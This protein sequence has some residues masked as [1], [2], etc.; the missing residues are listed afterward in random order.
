MKIH[1]KVHHDPVYPLRNVLLLLHNEHVVVEE[2]L[3]LLV[4]K[5]D[6]DLLET[7]VLE[8]LK[9]SN[10][11]DGHKVGLLHG[12]IAERAVALGNEPLEHTVIDCPGDTT[13]TVGGLV[14]VLTLGDPLGA[15]LEVRRCLRC[16]RF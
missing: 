4:D 1:S 5:V 11:Q 14:D 16:Y 12:G 2:L 6:G 9:P 13:H 8:N 10:I 3:Q 7:V 15:N